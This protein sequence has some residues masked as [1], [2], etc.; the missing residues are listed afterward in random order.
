[1]APS[2]RALEFCI[3]TAARSS[4]VLLAKRSEIDLKARMWI[5]PAQRMKARKVHRVPL[6]DSA[7]AII[8]AMPADSDWLF[9]GANQGKPL[10]NMSMQMT[11]RRMGLGDQAGTHGFRSTFRDWGSETGDYPNE[12]LEMAIAHTVGS[13]V[14]AAY[15]RGDLLKKRH[16]LM[17]D[18][19]QF[20]NSGGPH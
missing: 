2:A 18:W 3:L 14:E 5:V 9:P 1:M 13:K 10:S 16:Q 19:E 7:I 4:E 20:C 11:L 6:S 8:Q 12:L 17:A 15:R